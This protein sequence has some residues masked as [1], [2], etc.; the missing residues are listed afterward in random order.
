MS[1]P[2][3]PQLPQ[4]PTPTPRSRISGLGIAAIVLA[5]VAVLPTVVVLIIA[6]TPDQGLYAL[7]VVATV[8]F[9]FVIALLGLILGIGGI[10]HA[11]SRALSLIVPVIGAASATAVFVSVTLVMLLFFL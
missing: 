5:V 10:V 7:L 1:D 6:S 4:V 2:T 8:P 11:R 3:S 9:A